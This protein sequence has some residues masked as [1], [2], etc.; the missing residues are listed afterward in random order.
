MPQKETR[1]EG[2][3][4]TLSP[5]S[6]QSQ[7]TLGKWKVSG[8]L[9]NLIST[10]SIMKSFSPSP[11]IASLSLS[12]SDT[13]IIKLRLATFPDSRAIFKHAYSCVQ[14]AKE[15]FEVEYFSDTGFHPAIVS[16]RNHCT[17]MFE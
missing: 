16:L 17:A 12:L 1:G 2:G 14:K 15:I 6:R 3:K 4:E 9:V 10:I 11:Q 5:L 7:K 8:F 13:R